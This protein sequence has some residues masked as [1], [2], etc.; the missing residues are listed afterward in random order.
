MV[1]RFQSASQLGIEEAVVPS[2]PQGKE[3]LLEDP[4]HTCY[5]VYFLLRW[6]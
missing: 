3:E 4:G 6:Y 2:N 1:R 5:L